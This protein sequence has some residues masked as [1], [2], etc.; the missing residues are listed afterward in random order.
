MKKHKLTDSSSFHKKPLALAVLV[1]LQG[2]ALPEA[3]ADCPPPPVGPEFQVNTT[4][5]NDQEA[6][7]TAMDAQGNFVVVWQSNRQEGDDVFLRW[8][9]YAQRYNAAGEPQ[10]S[11]DPPTDCEFQVNTYTT[12]DQAAPAVAMDAASDFV[13]VWQSKGQD[14]SDYGVYAQR[15]NAAGVRQGSEFRV[16]TTTDDDQKA[17]AVAMDAA[18]DFVVTWESKGQ[19]GSDYGVYAQRYNAAGEPQG[20]GDPPQFEFK[21]NTTTQRDQINPAV[22]MDANGNFVVVWLNE[23]ESGSYRIH[24]QFYNAEGNPQGPELQVTDSFL[25]DNLHRPAVAMDAAGNNFVVAWERFSTAI[26]SSA[27]YARLYT[28]IN[29]LPQAQ[30]SEFQ[31]SISGG[32]SSSPAVAMDTS[33]NFVVNWLK[34]IASKGLDIYARRYDKNGH[35][36]DTPEF[37]VNTYPAGVSP[38]WHSTAVAMNSP[39]NFKIVW[40]SYDGKGTG[41]AGQRYALACRCPGP[42]FTNP[43]PE[44]YKDGEKKPQYIST[45][46]PTGQGPEGT[47][48]FIAKFC[49]NDP[50]A[51]P[52]TDLVSRTVAPPTGGFS[53]H[54][55]NRHYGPSQT[56][57]PHGDGDSPGEVGSVLDFPA[58]N[59][60]PLINGYNDHVLDVGECVD[61]KYEIGLQQRGRFSFYVDIY[62]DD[63][64]L[65]RSSVTG[66]P[67]P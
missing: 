51:K 34:T 59:D 53:N 1:A 57:T 6:P 50:D 38:D 19:D 26:S 37:R 4:T 18:G 67:C 7:A 13:V 31:V 3:F 36:L 23:V 62:G 60:P 28:F 48:T 10:K 29:G 11:G 8:G 21:V 61:V 24:A 2:A 43:P 39:S 25:A 42:A 49:N 12:S 56:A 35:A 22:A 58:N 32:S 30:G 40:Q 15:Y 65:P 47:F 33:G 45:P 63:A 17:P 20:S 14:G 55:L 41:I 44:I 66:L 52:L 64:T 46:S 9:I 5:A 27:T 54:L 16:N